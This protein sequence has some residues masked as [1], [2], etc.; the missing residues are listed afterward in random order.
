MAAQQ[1]HPL[2]R[3]RIWLAGVVLAPL[4][5]A[6][7]FLLAAWIGAAL[8]RNPGWSEP[9]RGVTI[10]VETNGVHTGIVM[11]VVSAVKDWRTTFPSAGQPR[12]LDGQLP[13]HMAVS[14]GE[15]EVFLETPTW[16]DLKPATVIRIVLY[17]GEGLMRVGHYV[18]PMP[19]EHHRPVT[20]RPEEYA[21]LVAR[22]EA[23]LPAL[24][25]GVKPRSYSS[26]EIGAQNYDALGRY[27]LT[28]TC[29]QWI[30]DALAHAGMTM[31]VWTPLAGGVMQWIDEP[32][33]AAGVPL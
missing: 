8:P 28:N 32:D 27:T 12:A 2:K 21:R 16:S 9:E 3:W 25:R 22:I 18:R 5:I 33:P 26:Y 24:P 6:A 14:W 1:P 4:L 15:K 13:T 20:L 30:G 7:A 11:P 23:A 17:G 10:M 29:N 19:S 31:G